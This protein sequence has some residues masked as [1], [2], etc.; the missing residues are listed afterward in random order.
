MKFK[1]QWN[2]RLAINYLFYVFRSLSSSSFLHRTLNRIVI[3]VC[4]STRIVE[5]FTAPCLW[6]IQTEQQANKIVQLSLN[7]YVWCR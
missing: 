7:D 4:L 6:F 5:A 1:I 3:F 2:F